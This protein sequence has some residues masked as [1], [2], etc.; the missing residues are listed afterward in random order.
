MHT[1]TTPENPPLMTENT[2]PSRDTELNAH[3]GIG[4]FVA[5]IWK[6]ADERQLQHHVRV[7]LAMNEQKVRKPKGGRRI[8][9][10]D[11][12][13]A[14]AHQKR[15]RLHHRTSFI[16]TTEGGGNVAEK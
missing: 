8:L 3:P 4:A 5:S 6:G 11:T 13:C 16:P 14:V 1:A 2:H 7:E 10:E 9:T 15:V 12:G